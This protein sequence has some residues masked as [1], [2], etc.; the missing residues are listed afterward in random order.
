MNGSGIQTLFYWCVIATF[1]MIVKS[2]ICSEARK[3]CQKRMGCGMALNNYIMSC[4]PLIHGETTQCSYE[5]KKALVSL[6][7]T[8]DH[9]GLNFMT[10]DCNNEEYCVTQ[11]RRI[12]VCSQPVLKALKGV[13]DEHTRINCSLAELICLTDP[14][15]NEA[16]RY[17]GDYCRK[18]FR[19]EK[20]TGRCNNSITILYRQERARKLRN[21]ICDGTESYNCQQIHDN[22][23]RLCF[24]HVSHR[25]KRPPYTHLDNVTNNVTPVIKRKPTESYPTCRTP[26]S[27]SSK[28]G[29]TSILLIFLCILPLI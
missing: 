4:G 16:L 26:N 14:G 8:Q 27:S 10:C 17:Y 18:L 12:Q 19:S 9:I 20:C 21:C 11:K 23:D 25:T 7:H 24:K 22:T 28:Y 15:C 6:L 29:W 3:K 13:N 1:S 5:C 2:E